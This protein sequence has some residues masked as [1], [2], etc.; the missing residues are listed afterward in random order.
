MPHNGI[1]PYNLS[2]SVTVDGAVQMSFYI[3]ALGAGESTTFAMAH[4]F[5]ADALE[6]APDATYVGGYDCRYPEVGGAFATAEKH[7]CIRCVHFISR[8]S[9][10]G[11][12]HLPV[13]E[14][15]RRYHLC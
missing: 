4:V 13:A 1:T 9:C 12:Y 11:R 3:P 10:S 2:G 6:E 8:C 7:L 14:F 15:C 5:S